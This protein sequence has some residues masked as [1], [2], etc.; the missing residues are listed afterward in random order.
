MRCWLTLM[1]C[2]ALL[3]GPA[4]AL[5]LTLPGNATQSVDVLRA[6]DSYMLPVGPF[7]DGT[8]PVIGVEGRVHQ[9][10]W[11]IDQTGM[12]TLQLIRPFRDELTRAGYEILLDCSGQEC[13]GFDF[14]FNTKVLPAPDMYVD[15]FDFRFLSARKAGAAGNVVSV[16]V[17]QAG[18]AGYVQVIQ[19]IANGD[20]DDLRVTAAATSTEPAQENLPLIGALVEQGHVILRDLDFGTGSSALGPGPHGTLEALAGYLLA[21]KKR[22]IALVGHTDRVGTL[23]DN[24]TL[25][26]RR[27]NSVLER[28]AGE[29]DVPRAQLEANGVGYLSPIAPNQ[30]AEGREANRRVEAILL[31]TE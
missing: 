14:R 21:D 20:T 12:T 28:L 17:S 31:S 13:G 11:R 5:D 16:I 8:L 3:T 18:G 9:Q 7:A 27:A 10:A 22:R 29:H 2:A 26:R 15:L 23:E 30:T 1:A 25:S 24:I 4:R 6:A 19:V